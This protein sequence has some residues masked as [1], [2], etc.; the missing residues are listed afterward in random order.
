MRESI[1]GRPATYDAD[2]PR[3]ASDWDRLV[4]DARAKVTAWA[5]DPTTKPDEF[6]AAAVEV[7]RRQDRRRDARWHRANQAL[8]G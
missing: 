1:P 5:N 3:E 4:A 7:E 8:G 6:A 2:T